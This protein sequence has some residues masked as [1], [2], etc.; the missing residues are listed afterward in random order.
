M[1]LAT[2]HLETYSLSP[3]GS[4]KGNGRQTKTCLGRVFNYK[5]GRFYDVH[6]FIYVDAQPHL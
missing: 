2:G 1:K 4:A 6:V 5:L 3:A